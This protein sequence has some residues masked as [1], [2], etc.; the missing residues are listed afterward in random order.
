MLPSRAASNA[1]ASLDRGPGSLRTRTLCLGRKSNATCARP[2][3]WRSRPGRRSTRQRREDA[4][5]SQTL[6]LACASFHAGAAYLERTGGRMRSLCARVRRGGRSRAPLHGARGLGGVGRD[7]AALQLRCLLRKAE[8]AGAACA[9]RERTR[10]R[11]VPRRFLRP[12]DEGKIAPDSD[13]LLPSS[14]WFMTRCL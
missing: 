2:A 8:G 6:D 10:A 1:A 12:S 14:S 5:G 3:A 13:D 4:A 11:R 9:C 7:A